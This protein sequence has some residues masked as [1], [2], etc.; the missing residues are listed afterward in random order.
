MRSALLTTA[1]FAL[2]G[3]YSGVIKGDDGSDLRLFAGTLIVC[4]Q[5]SGELAA[6]GLATSYESC[7][8][9]LAPPPPDTDTG[10]D[11]AS[12]SI[13]DTS[14]DTASDTAAASDSG[15]SDTEGGLCGLYN[16]LFD[17]P[18]YCTPWRVQAN[19]AG[20]AHTLNLWV[21]G[22]DDRADLT[23]AQAPQ[24]ILAH[25]PDPNGVLPTTATELQGSIAVT[26]DNGRKATVKLDTNKGTGKLKLQVCR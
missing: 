23:G 6:F 3:C 15:P 19:S 7:P 9:L 25:C 17:N 21:E 22:F 1:A 10:D 13:I 18:A 5:A 11:S 20:N 16:E 24:A 2:T 14:G 26:R 4:E 12:T 8:H